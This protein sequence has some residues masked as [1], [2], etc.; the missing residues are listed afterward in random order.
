MKTIP[1]HRRSH[2]GGVMKWACPGFSRTSKKIDG[3]RVHRAKD[4]VIGSNASRTDAG[5]FCRY[6]QHSASN[7]L[8]P[9]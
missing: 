7:K 6:L 8:C 9:P 1:G 3:F 5:R 2:G 4:I